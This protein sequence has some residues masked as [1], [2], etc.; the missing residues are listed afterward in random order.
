MTNKNTKDIGKNRFVERDRI[1]E[2][3]AKKEQIKRESLK[4]KKVINELQITVLKE[5]INVPKIKA[6]YYSEKTLMMRRK[7][8][9]QR[10]K[11]QKDQILKMKLTN[12]S[13][14]MSFPP[15]EELAAESLFLNINVGG[16]NILDCV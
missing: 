14:Q 11:C 2:G 4:S 15:L 1:A 10:E 13:T 3:G 5:E 12:A 6:G 9:E 16:P 8:V 7:D